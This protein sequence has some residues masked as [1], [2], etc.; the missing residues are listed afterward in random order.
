MR[1]IQTIICLLLVMS[2]AAC[3]GGEARQ[4]RHEGPALQGFHIY[5]SFGVDSELDYSS[6]LALDPYEYEGWFELF[7]YVDSRWDYTVLIG[8]N[9][10]PSMRGA[11]I[12]GSD[13]CGAGLSCDALGTFICRYTADGY[14][15]CGLVEEEAE[16][17]LASVDHLLFEY[18]QDVYINMEVCGVGGGGCE[19]SSLPVWLY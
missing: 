3:D 1:F 7:W 11:T 18:P 19:V 2:L 8:V 13:L 5:D 12:I 9:D 6:P 15:G 17:N 14:V 10:S 16:L 4:V